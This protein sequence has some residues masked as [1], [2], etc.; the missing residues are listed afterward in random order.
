LDGWRYLDGRGPRGRN[1][2]N[3]NGNH[4]EKEREYAEKSQG[5]ALPNE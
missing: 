2:E 3:I 1:E 4:S 5:E